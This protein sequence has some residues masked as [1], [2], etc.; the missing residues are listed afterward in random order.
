MI[1]TAFAAIALASTPVPG[2]VTG[3]FDANGHP[4][5]A[6]IIR[7]ADGSRDIVV[8][9]DDGREMLVESRVGEATTLAVVSFKR[10]DAVC[11]PLVG[12]VQDACP[13]AAG[14]RDGLTYRRSPTEVPSLAVWTGMRFVSLM[15]ALK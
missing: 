6:T 3:D 1:L 12:I 5:S 14:K 15:G 2:A 13:R 10:V 11:A 8:R 9:L 7:R 4:D